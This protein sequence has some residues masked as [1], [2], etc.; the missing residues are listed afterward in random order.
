M[1]IDFCFL[2][3]NA[4]FCPLIYISGHVGPNKTEADDDA[5][6]AERMHLLKNG[7]L[8]L[9]VVETSPRREREFVMG[10]EVMVRDGDFWRGWM[11]GSVCWAVATSV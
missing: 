1:V 4:F 9:F 7:L 3:R 8:E 6:M 11:E 2:T 5:G 10:M